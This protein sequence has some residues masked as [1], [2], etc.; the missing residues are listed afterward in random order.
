[1]NIQ[2]QFVLIKNSIKNIYKDSELLQVV[3][4]DIAEYIDKQLP[5]DMSVSDQCPESIDGYTEFKFWIYHPLLVKFNSDIR[6]SIRFAI[7]EPTASDI[8]VVVNHKDDGVCDWLGDYTLSFKNFADFHH[9]CFADAID[10][11][12]KPQDSQGVYAKLMERQMPSVF[13]DKNKEVFN[14]ISDYFMKIKDLL[15]KAN[16]QL[17]FTDFGSKER[18]Q[19]FYLVPKDADKSA[20]TSGFI[21]CQFPKLGFHVPYIVLTPNYPHLDCSET[22]KKG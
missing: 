7:D 16:A 13:A 9:N 3:C 4:K 19:P 22:L 18:F 8:K 10:H 12:V 20:K 1:M 15:E 14:T 5:P 21:Y 17:L 2:A 6:V 11:F